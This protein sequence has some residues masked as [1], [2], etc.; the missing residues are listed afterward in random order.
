[1]KEMKQLV[2]VPI[3]L[4][5]EKTETLNQNLSY[6]MLRFAPE[7]RCSSYSMKAWN[8]WRVAGSPLKI[9][10]YTLTDIG[11]YSK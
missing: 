9:E 6:F 4:C 1:M 5:V 10:K 8:L 7:F 3:K 2:T 11:L